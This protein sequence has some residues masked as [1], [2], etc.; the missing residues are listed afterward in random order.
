MAKIKVMGNALTLVS[1]LKTED[2][3]K[4]QRLEPEALKLFK[5]DPETNAKTEYFGITLTD[6]SSCCSHF[7]VTFSSTNS[8]GYAY[9][10]IPI[11]RDQDTT[12]EEIAEEFMPILAN[13][14]DVEEIFNTKYEALKAKIDKTKE[15]VEFLD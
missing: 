3:A 8:E 5:V 7:G 4:V 13:L 14:N 2:I 11:T 1:T 12:E 6:G 10:T 15:D 9:I